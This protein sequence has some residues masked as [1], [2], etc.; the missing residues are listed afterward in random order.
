MS[1][2]TFEKKRHIWIFIVFIL[3]LHMIIYVMTEVKFN[4]NIR[5]K[6]DVLMNVYT[7]WTGVNINIYL[8]IM[9]LR[10]IVF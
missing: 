2:N 1:E 5:N 8:L 4:G 7:R 3:M 10:H 9:I 6:P